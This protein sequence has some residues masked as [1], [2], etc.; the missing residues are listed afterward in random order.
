[1]TLQF[2]KMLEVD[3]SETMFQNYALFSSLNTYIRKVILNICRKHME[4]NKSHN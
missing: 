2:S 1:M 3:Y 4:L